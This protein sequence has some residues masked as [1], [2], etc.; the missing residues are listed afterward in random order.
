MISSPIAL[1]PVLVAGLLLGLGCAGGIQ[2]A[3]VTPADLPAL[4][5]A[6]AAHPNDPAVLTRLGAGYY[7]AGRTADAIRVLRTAL[8]A[9]AD[10]AAGA[11]L[12]L[13]FEAQNQSDSAFAAYRRAEPLARTGAERA[14]VAARLAAMTRARL[15]QA[16]KDAV[17]RETELARATPVPNSIA[18]MPWSYLGTDPELRPLERGITHLI[19]TDLSRVPSLVLLER[20]RVQ[21]LVDELKLSAAGRVEATTGARS[22]RLLRAARIVN[23]SIREVGGSQ[24]VR[25]DANAVLTTTGRIAATGTASNRLESLFAMEKQVVLAL[26]DQL[27]INLGPAERQ[28]ISERPTADLQAFLAFSRGLAASDR[29]DFAGAA[30]EFGRAAARDPNFREARDR[31][32]RANEIASAGTGGPAGLDALAQASF[33]GAV[34]PTT[35][36]GR[37]AALAHAIAIVAPSFGSRLAFR[38]LAPL[39]IARPS[40]PEGFRQDDPTDLGGQG[41]VIIVVPR[42]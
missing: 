30:A 1:R 10:F 2:P 28:A 7:H 15:A 5:A 22:G 17:T 33:P 19:V 24:N 23:G 26:L 27:G 8:A 31:A 12:G 9:R 16:A 42:P 32:A 29:G 3:A 40:V 37:A 41:R 21:A 39:P 36:G 25:L 18:V 13:A 20:E 38:S 6:R 34:G 35:T 11:Y 14:Q 4:E